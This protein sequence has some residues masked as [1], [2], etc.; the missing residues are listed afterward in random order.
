MTTYDPQTLYRKPEP[1]GGTRPAALVLGAV[2]A[3]VLVGGV[4]SWRLWAPW[5]GAQ[6]S[7]QTI[8][9]SSHNSAA[10]AAAPE[11]E[12]YTPVAMPAPPAPLPVPSGGALPVPPPM[13][14]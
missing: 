11:P 7:Y 13:V 1:T 8:V 14:F 2:G 5:S 6:V 4:L 12:R 9:P 3:V 10:K